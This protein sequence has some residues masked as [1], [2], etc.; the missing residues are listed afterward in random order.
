MIKSLVTDFNIIFFEKAPQTT[1]AELSCT[2]SYDLF[3]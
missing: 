2:L 3:G 1:A